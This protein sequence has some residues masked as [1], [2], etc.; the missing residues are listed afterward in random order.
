[1]EIPPRDAFQRRI[2]IQCELQLGHR[3]DHEAKVEVA[4][5]GIEVIKWPTAYLTRPPKRDTSQEALRQVEQI[6]D[7]KPVRGETLLRS[8]KL[9]RQRAQARKR[10]ERSRSRSKK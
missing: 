9:K 6:T 8:R 1:M 3:Q 7:S 10:G 2:V 4:T 5:G